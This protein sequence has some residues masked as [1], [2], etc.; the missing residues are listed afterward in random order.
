M[1]NYKHLTLDDRNLIAQMLSKRSSFMDIASAIGKNPVTISREVR[2]H[3]CAEKSGTLRIGYNA[4]I[5]RKDCQIPRLSL[6]SICHSAKKYR[7][8]RY[9][10]MCNSFCDRFEKETCKK[11]LKAPYVCNGCPDRMNCTLE[12]KFYRP[13][14]AQN[15]YQELLSECRSGISVSEDEIARIEQVM[16]PLVGQKQS[17]HHI[18]VHNG[19]QIMVSERSLYRMIDD[20][21]FSFP[22]YR[23]DLPR[24]VRY[25]VR[26]K[27]RDFKVDKA[28]RIG[29]DWQAYLRKM[30]ESPDTA[31]VQMD[32]VEGK[33]GGAVLLTLHFVKSEFMLAFYR[34]HNDSRSV[35][36][37]FNDLYEK[38]GPDDFKKIFPLLLGD[39]GSEFSNPAAIETTKEGEQRTQVFY[40]DP[41]APQQK[42]SAERNH[43]FIRYFLPKGKDFSIYDQEHISLMMDHI[44]SY[45]RGSLGNKCPYE[46]FGFLYGRHILEKLGCRRIPPKEV[47]LNSSVFKEVSHH[48]S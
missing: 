37:I 27:K 3:S 5:H 41:N 47:T 4:C 19:D 24:K 23:I 42:G 10:G 8:C 32:S 40:C 9:C 38:L 44:N 21:L 34:E 18:C 6:C 25:K 30:E 48:D 39:N 46:M 1:T 45:S 2:K 14:I 15:N 12:K 20:G 36:D 22:Q 11:L 35:T 13:G 31:I 7:F 29:R 28:C 33:K 43:E 16:A 26:K 17:V